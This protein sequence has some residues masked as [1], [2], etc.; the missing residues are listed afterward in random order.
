MTARTL[1]MRIAACLLAIVP[2]V[3]AAAQD[4]GAR[5]RPETFARLAVRSIGPSLMSGRI[6]DI[7]IHPRDRATWYIA[8]GSGGVW[9]TVNNGT[10]WTPIFEHQSSYSVGAISIDPNNPEV[11][12][13]GSG[14]NVSGRHV[15]YGDGVYKSLDGGAS[16]TNMG[17]GS[18]EHI[19][20]IL[21]DPRD[22]DIVFVA[23]EGPLWVSGG[24]RG[25][26]RSNDGGGSWQA[27]LTFGNDT[28]V[29]D[30]EFD[31]ADPETLYA[32]SYQRRRKVWALLAGGPESG[33]HKSTDGGETWRQ[34]RAG[35]PTGDLGKIGLAVSPQHPEVVYATIEADD[36]SEGFY[37]SA[38]GGESWTKRNGYRS[39]GT[40]PHYY[41]EIYAS[42]HAFDRIYQMDVWM[43]VSEDGG[44][45]FAELGEPQK[46]SD[47]HALAFVA[48]DPDYLLAG[49]DGGLYE[50]YDHGGSWKFVSN[51]PVTQ[52]Y[53]MALDDAEPFYNVIGGTQDNGTIYGPSRTASVHGVQN[54]DWTVP[55][56]ADGY[57]TQIDPENP[58]LLYVTWQNGHL[59]R[60]DTN[61]REPLDIQPQ[62][63]PNDP[64]E[65]WNWDAPVL[66]SPHSAARLYFGSQRLWRSDDR[67]NSWRAISGDL[68]RGTN[69]YELPMMEAVPGISALYDNGA[70]SWYSN[71]TSISESPLVE[72]LIY[73]GTDD[74]LIQVT[75]DGGNTWRTVDGVAG[76]PANSFISEI[77]ASVHDPA[78]VFAVLVNHKQGDYSPYLVKSTDRGL[79]WT[80][81][82][83]DLPDR[84][85]LWSMAQD[86][87]DPE[88]LFVGTEF[89]LFFSADG[90]GHW[91][92]LRGGV[93]N[94]PF[95]DIEIQRRESDLVAAS[96]GRGFYILDDYSSLRTLNEASLAAEAQLFPVR[97]TVLYVPSVD[98]GV[99]GQ[100]YQ[101]SSYYTAANPLF[102]AMITY[103]L[104]DEPLTERA[105]RETTEAELRAAGDDVP[106]P[107]W[108]RLQQE[109]DESEPELLAT[110]TDADGNVVR[111]LQ[112]ESSAGFHRIAWDLRYPSPD[113]IDLNP[114]PVPLWSNEPAGPLVAP[115]NYTVALAR[116][117]AS[118]L[119][120]LGEP[121]SFEIRRLDGRALPAGDPAATLA[122]QQQTAE[123]QRRAM[124]A[125]ESLSEARTRLRHMHQAVIETPGADPQLLHRIGQHQQRLRGF[126]QR[127]TGNRV[128]GALNEP[129]VPSILGRIGQISSGHW[130][131]TE[132]PTQTFRDSLHV[133]AQQLEALEMEMSQANT[134]LGELEAALEAAG[135]PWT[136]GRQ[137]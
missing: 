79:T 55:Y 46:H 119:E 47:N 25:V 101:G 60:Y 94:I 92:K 83:G 5:M 104:R 87:I 40:G 130:Y 52:I 21:I 89:G 54:R 20:K 53:K 26:Y 136:P 109:A 124:A 103:Y 31:P 125:A 133:A 113:P 102:G 32:A 110:I 48:D 28:G 123:L 62:P 108:E 107:G 13:V 78:T 75:E 128:R 82:V 84:H 16:W 9:K 11:I 66:I 135:A 27:I 74:G 3:P 64:P 29:T 106:F 115:G 114:G 58:D 4:D 57:A 44:R 129:S 65:R 69:R 81:I 68:S 91:L 30:L 63:G 93:P 6:A 36:E 90:G 131:T 41:Q 8:V 126:G 22:S 98:L 14:E 33:I 37:R 86:H 19:A 73:V 12:W 34:L 80:S 117:T 51:L 10:T 1:W 50:S 77:K 71:T 35:L 127:L 23:A 105:R 39:G 100:G 118:G 38:N 96:F 122:F 42:P 56:G 88:L 137:R 72:G 45:T 132:A 120:S 17:L 97:D 43:H 59:L 61:T 7:A 67:G 111:R 99:R 70:M 134:E 85:L 95:R 24:E 49:S 121:Q 18:S 116:L 2:V 76:V 15:G 112:A